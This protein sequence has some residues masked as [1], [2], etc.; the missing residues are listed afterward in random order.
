MFPVEQ[1]LRKVVGESHNDVLDGS[2]AAGGAPVTPGSTATRGRT[3]SVASVDSTSASVRTPNNRS[4]KSPQP[5]AGAGW[6]FGN[7]YNNANQSR[8]GNGG[9]AAGAAGFNF[10]VPGVGADAARSTVQRPGFA[11]NI[12]AEDVRRLLRKRPEL[13]EFLNLEIQNMKLETEKLTNKM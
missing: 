1:M 9:G 13:I 5:R 6:G 2:N 8:G 7:N 3:T 4:S 10:S 12:E 11:V